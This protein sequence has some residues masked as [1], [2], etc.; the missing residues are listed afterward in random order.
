MAGKER[1]RRPG[2]PRHRR[3]GDTRRLQ[4]PRPFGPHKDQLTASAKAPLSGNRSDAVVR[5][6]GHRRDHDAHQQPEGRLEDP[7]RRQPALSRLTGN[8][9]QAEQAQEEPGPVSRQRSLPGK[10]NRR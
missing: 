1:R 6:S 7:I 5:P 2:R 4:T 8:S 9:D 10:A 3:H